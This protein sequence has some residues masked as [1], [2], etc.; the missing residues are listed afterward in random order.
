MKPSRVITIV[1][2]ALGLFLIAIYMWGPSAVPAGQQPL[3]YLSDSNF[4]EFA[5]AFDAAGEAPRLLLLLSPT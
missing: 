3:L 2:A 1:G 5:K 4:G